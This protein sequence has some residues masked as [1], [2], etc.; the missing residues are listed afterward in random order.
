MRIGEF[1]PVS[2]C[3][4]AIGY[5]RLVSQ[6]F[7]DDFDLDMEVGDPLIYVFDP[8]DG[9]TAQ[10][11]MRLGIEIRPAT[12]G[13]EVMAAAS[14]GELGGVIIAPFGDEELRELFMVAL[15]GKFPEINVVYVDENAQDPRVQEE[16]R[17]EGAKLILPWPLPQ[18][19]GSQLSAIFGETA[20]ASP[21]STEAE[22]QILV[23]KLGAMDP[24]ARDTLDLIPK[25]ELELAAEEATSLRSELTLVRERSQLLQR[26][27]ERLTQDL[28]SVTQQRDSLERKL[29]ND[30]DYPREAGPNALSP[31]IQK[32]L[33]VLQKV[34]SN[35]ENFVWGIEQ[36][37]Q[38]LEE[39]SF[40]A[41]DKRAPTLKSHIKILRL[42][43]KLLTQLQKYSK[44]I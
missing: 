26:R 35:A 12:T 28:A 14:N 2:G 30:S 10:T 9:R 42:T 41:G 20:A 37:I 5:T 17:A 29:K 22:R 1:R 36:T 11:L 7:D 39:L 40:E 21:A 38:F 13:S 34:G 8:G 44:G 31:E 18:D 24:P 3:F 6:A 4:L 33:S 23:R 25:K 32:R 15:R 27:I 43:R 16:A 19:V